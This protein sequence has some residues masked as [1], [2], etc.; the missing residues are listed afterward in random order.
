MNKRTKLAE[1]KL[2]NYTRGEEIFNMVTHIVGAAFGVVMLVLGIVFAAVRGHVAGVLTAIVFGLSLIVLYTMS[3][4]YHGLSPHIKGKK[5]MQILDHC[6][7][8]L[9]IAGS[10]TPLTICALV[11]ANPVLGWTI[12]ALVWIVSIIGIILNSIDIK[13]YQ[14]F[15]MICYLGLG[16][17]IVV[18][19]P[20]LVSV[21]PAIAIWLLLLGGIAY[22]LGAILF[23]LGCKIKYMHSIFH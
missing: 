20:V 4:V 16:W 10:Y 12:F 13:K 17:C 2:P 11:P 15:S 18:S 14:A 1:R 7:V 3:A 21:L 19:F 22:T 8:F 23:G 9:L 5:V 6:S